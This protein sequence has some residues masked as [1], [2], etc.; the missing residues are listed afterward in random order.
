MGLLSKFNS[1]QQINNFQ[2][3]TTTTNSENNITQITMTLLLNVI[4]QLYNL[5][6]EKNSNYGNLAKEVIIYY[7]VLLYYISDDS[8]YRSEYYLKKF[9]YNPNYYNINILMNC[10]F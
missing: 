2:T 6:D 4:D 8:P 7:K 9:L 5:A 3:T 10:I 1:I